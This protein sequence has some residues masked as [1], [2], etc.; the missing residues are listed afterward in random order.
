[1]KKLVA[2]LAVSL[3]LGA[4]SKSTET[5]VPTRM[6]TRLTTA[7]TS[8]LRLSK[9]ISKKVIKIGTDHFENSSYSEDV[10]RTEAIAVK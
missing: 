1:M 7:R 2:K 4:C 5:P 8:I 3:A 9:G 10:F 6:P